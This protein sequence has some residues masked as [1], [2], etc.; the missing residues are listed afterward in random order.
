MRDVRDAAAGGVEYAAGREQARPAWERRGRG[1]ACASQ[2]IVERAAIDAE[3]ARE[4][5]DRQRRIECE[6]DRSRQDE[7]GG[8]AERPESHNDFLTCLVVAS[9]PQG[10]AHDAVEIVVA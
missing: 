5:I 1:Q 6:S 10:I 7:Q 4:S 3:L 9:L 2:A 8:V